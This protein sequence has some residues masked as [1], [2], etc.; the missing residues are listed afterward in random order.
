MRIPLLSAQ[1]TYTKKILGMSPAPLAYYPLW[2]RAGTVAYDITGHGYN[3]TY[4]NITLAQPG[5]GDGNVAAQWAAANSYMDFYSAAF[6]TAFNGKEFAVSFW[7]KLIDT[8]NWTPASNIVPLM[9]Q[10]DASNKL[11]LYNDSGNTLFI[12]YV[13]GGTTKSGGFASAGLRMSTTPNWVNFFI[14]ALRSD[15][16]PMLCIRIPVI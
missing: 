4:G 7:V 3:G 11:H 9:I 10:V 6:N 1:Q 12:F 5:I 8:A 16:P 13:A 14:A 2:E 15:T